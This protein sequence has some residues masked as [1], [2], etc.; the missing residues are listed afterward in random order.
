M[1]NRNITITLFG[2]F[3]IGGLWLQLPLSAYHSGESARYPS[4]DEFSIT[5]QSEA[6]DQLRVQNLYQLQEQIIDAIT[7]NNIK[8]SRFS[9]VM[10]ENALVL[11]QAY[12]DSNQLELSLGG[13]TVKDKSQYQL[14]INDIVS[15]IDKEVD[16]HYTLMNN[17]ELRIEKVQVQ[18]LAVDNTNQLLR[19]DPI[20]SKILA[21]A[22]ENPIAYGR[23]NLYQNGKKKALFLTNEVSQSN[24]DIIN[25]LAINNIKSE[26][27]VLFQ[28][29]TNWAEVIYRHYPSSSRFSRIKKKHVQVYLGE[30]FKKWKNEYDQREMLE[31]IADIIDEKKISTDSKTFKY[32]KD[33]RKIAAILRNGFYS[34]TQEGKAPSEFEKYVKTFGKLNDALQAENKKEAKIIAKKLKKIL[35]EQADLENLKLDVNYISA[36]K[37]EKRMNTLAQEISIALESEVL[38]DH[39]FHKMRKQLKLFLLLSNDFRDYQEDSP[40]S[41]QL[42]DELDHIIT[43]L[44]DWHDTHISKKLQGLD[45]IESYSISAMDRRGIQDS[46]FRASSIMLPG[47]CHQI[48]RNIIH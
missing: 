42:S 23:F 33:Q 19:N 20:Q 7:N 1:V 28:H 26:E 15:T 46:V 29:R 47:S 16:Y 17:G 8:A 25:K 24:N 27:V 13:N 10:Q 14:V 2:L 48:L 3:I 35:K 39:E 21:S 11:N 9:E 5:Y 37:L 38:S 41:K 45:V 40:I 43:R 32:L 12:I 4:S 6:S 22:N 30:Q 36:D 31:I 44:G 34:Y 18:E